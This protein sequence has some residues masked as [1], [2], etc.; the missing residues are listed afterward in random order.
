MDKK[1]YCGNGGVAFHGKEGSVGKMGYSV[2]SSNVDPISK[3]FPIN[4]DSIQVGDYIYCPGGIYKRVAENSTDASLDPA[5]FLKIVGDIHFKNS[6]TY[7]IFAD[8]MVRKICVNNKVLHDTSFSSSADSDYIT[9]G[10]AES[11]KTLDAFT[12]DNSW[13]TAGYP[14]KFAGEGITSFNELKR[15]NDT[16]ITKIPSGLFEN[17]SLLTSVSL[18]PFTTE[19]GDSA[20]KNC[21]L[22]DPKDASGKWIFNESGVTTLGVESF[23]G[24]SSIEQFSLD[25]ISG[26]IP[27]M[28]FMD[29]KSLK[30]MSA[31]SSLTGMGPSA[32]EGCVGLAKADISLCTSLMGTFNGN[33]S[34]NDVGISDRAFAGCTSL[35]TVLLPADIEEIGVSAFEGDSSIAGISVYDVHTI[36]QNAFKNCS[37]LGNI[38]LSRDYAAPEEIQIGQ[39]ALSGAAKARFRVPSKRYYKCAAA[40][41]WAPYYSEDPAS[42]KM[43]PYDWLVD[44]KFTYTDPYNG[45][46]TAMPLAPNSY[47]IKINGTEYKPDA[48]GYVNFKAI[49]ASGNNEYI[50]IGTESSPVKATVSL[51]DYD[52]SSLVPETPYSETFDTSGWIFRKTFHYIPDVIPFADSYLLQACIDAGYDANGNHRISSKEALNKKNGT[53]SSK[54]TAIDYD[55]FQ[56][57]KYRSYDASTGQYTQTDQYYRDLITSFDELGKYFKN[58]TSM[59]GTLGTAPL[60]NYTALKSVSIPYN[61]CWSTDVSNGLDYAFYNDSN[62]ATITSDSSDFI[63]PNVSTNSLASLNYTFYNTALATGPSIPSKVTSMNYTYYDCSKMTTADIGNGTVKNAE[64]TFEKC[65]SLTSITGT[66]SKDIKSM[67]KTFANTAITASIPTA[68]YS[69]ATMYH[70]YEDCSK[71]ITGAI[72]QGI[73]AADG[74]QYTFSGCSNMTSLAAGYSIP[75]YSELSTLNHT[76]SGCTSLATQPTI[77][78]NI[79]TLNGTFSQCSAIKSAAIGNGVTTMVDAYINSGLQ[80]VAIPTNVTS[81]TGSFQYCGGLTSCSIYAVGTMSKSFSN[82]ASLSSADISTSSISLKGTFSNCTSLST[83]SIA[84]GTA[85]I[86]ASAIAGCTAL[87]KVYIYNSDPSKTTIDTSTFLDVSTNV[88]II[89]PDDY[90]F[91]YRNAWGTGKGYN[92]KD[93]NILPTNDILIYDMQLTKALLFPSDSTYTYVN[94]QPEMS[95]ESFPV[96]YTAS[97]GTVTTKTYTGGGYYSTDDKILYDTSTGKYPI[98][99]NGDTAE[100]K[101]VYRYSNRYIIGEDIITTIYGYENTI[102]YESLN[103]QM[104]MTSSTIAELFVQPVLSANGTIGGDSFAIDTSS[105]IQNEN[106]AWKAFDDSRSTYWEFQNDASTTTD[107]SDY[108]F[109]TNPTTITIYNPKA[110][111]LYGI[112]IIQTTRYNNMQ[113]IRAFKIEGSNDNLSWVTLKNDINAYAFNNYYNTIEVDSSAAY[114]YHKL[115]IYRVYKNA[116]NPTTKISHIKIFGKES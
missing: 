84:A 67:N 6:G 57:G 42:S 55:V 15:F 33:D 105:K 73:S 88:K 25:N 22:L 56:N 39:N 19:I 97:D 110:I 99:K 112:G 89:T 106:D 116:K 38:Y 90:V 7:I 113:A 93:S 85:T 66:F 29:A 52:T 61:V 44:I 80:N 1:I 75:S 86:D 54:I 59:G 79:T 14:Y 104:T 51:E 103:V 12:I 26:A 34:T 62:L 16:S 3:A 94:Y 46:T 96:T 5:D 114:K 37:G 40:S 100:I 72:S 107:Y 13:G 70:T 4:L 82:C 31:P 77:P 8:D 64:S 58:V 50:S 74:L 60:A 32:Y 21:S 9:Y 47:L 11:L 36:G 65:T 81:D 83:I 48:S 71:L 63:I 35:K 92:L 28:C 20:F 115:T 43:L 18:P 111:L 10:Q 109:Y 24:C 27:Q 49:D 78:S 98:L 87:K 69:L 76:F 2:H 41:G 53:L 30:E 68:E 101:G 23:H 45:V 108:S 91:T 95:S 17:C 102:Y